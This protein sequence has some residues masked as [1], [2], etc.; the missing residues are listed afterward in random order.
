MI[1][2]AL[3]Q[4]PLTMG[5][6]CLPTH[7][8]VISAVPECITEIDLVLNNWQNP[9]TGSLTCAVRPIMVEK[10]KCKPL[11]LPLPRK[12]LHQQQCFIPG[13]TAEIGTII[14]DFKDT[15]AMI[16]T[17]FP[18]NLPVWSVQKTGRSWRMTMHYC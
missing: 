1:N 5:P 17:M 2:G 6:V 10:A 9:H 3:A 4:F 18:F 15:R 14:K 16:S 7:P 13:K 8:V 12:I 11:E